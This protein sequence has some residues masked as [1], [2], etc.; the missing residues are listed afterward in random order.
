MAKLSAGG[1]KEQ[2]RLVKENKEPK[3]PLISW[4]REVI[5]VMESGKVLINRTVIFAPTPG[6]PKPKRH[7]YGWKL[8]KSI[9]TYAERVAYGIEKSQDG[10]K[11]V[12]AK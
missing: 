1:Q 11:V 9:P 3:S 2:Y 6:F 5:A 7:S 12:A 4:E 8:V 10:W